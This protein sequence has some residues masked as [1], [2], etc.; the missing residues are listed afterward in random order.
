M[1]RPKAQTQDQIR[2]AAKLAR[3][4]KRIV[5]ATAKRIAN[6]RAERNA[7]RLE[8]FAAAPD[9]QWLARVGKVQADLRSAIACLDA[10]RSFLEAARGPLA[11]RAIRHAQADARTFQE[12]LR[13][14]MPT[15]I[16]PTCYAGQPDCQ[17]CGGRGCLSIRE[18]AE[19]APAQLHNRE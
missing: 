11:L 17:L 4:R 19:L 7:P 16:C 15:C 2:F 14:L 3:A 6:A 13:A 9:P 12:S 5:K 1:T 18:A 8:L 10:V